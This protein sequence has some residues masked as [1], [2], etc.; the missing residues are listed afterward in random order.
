MRLPCSLRTVKMMVPMSWP[1]RHS[2]MR[3]RWMLCDCWFLVSTDLLQSERHRWG[4]GRRGG[5]GWRGEK[6]E[7]GV[8]SLGWDMSGWKERNGQEGMTNWKWV[9]GEEW[10]R[11]K[12]KVENERDCKS[13]WT[14][15]IK[16]PLKDGF[17]K[18]HLWKDVSKMVLQ[19]PYLK[20]CNYLQKC[21]GLFFKT[22][23]V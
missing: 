21:H 17:E 2:V 1:I 15:K 11:G 22:A 6:G 23:I 12:W 13:A 7:E 19:E 5:K 16:D 8:W 9:R 18:N 4:R 14:M 3:V 20:S 10:A